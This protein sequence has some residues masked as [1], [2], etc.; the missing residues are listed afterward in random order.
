M[1]TDFNVPLKQV[2][3]LWEI[4]DTKRIVATLPSINYCLEN[5][6]KSLVM[7]SHLGRPAGNSNE[8]F[9]LKPLVPAIEDLLQRKVK[10]LQNC[11]GEEVEKEC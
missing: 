1:R 3:G 9:S 11:V 6:A 2:N 5:K 8:A 7:M 4:S 10:F